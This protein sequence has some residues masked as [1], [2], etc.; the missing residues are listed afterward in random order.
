MN[1]VKLSDF[2]SQTLSWV[3]HSLQ[4]DIRGLQLDRP[5]FDA[6]VDKLMQFHVQVLYAFSVVQDRERVNAN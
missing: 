5:L 6:E 4:K 1:D 2:D 3:A